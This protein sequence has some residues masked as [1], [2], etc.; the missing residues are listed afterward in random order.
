MHAYKDQQSTPNSNHAPLSDGSIA[1][2]FAHQQ[3]RSLLKQQL[4][5]QVSPTLTKK[6]LQTLN[7]GTATTIL[8]AHKPSRELVT[9]LF[10]SLFT[11][12]NA[13]YQR[14]DIAYAERSQ[15]F[16]SKH[17]LVMAP[18]YCIHTMKDGLRVSAYMRAI[19]KAITALIGGGQEKIFIAYPA[20]GPFAPLLLPLLSHYQQQGL[21]GERLRI[22]LIDIQPGA[23][24]SLHRLITELGLQEYIQQMYCGDAC[25]YNAPMLFDL[26]IVE[27]MQHGF[28]REGHFAIAHHFAQQLSNNGY[29]IPQQV[30]VHAMLNVAQL[31][32]VEQWRNE[33]LGD[34]RLS[35]KLAA[36]TKQRTE[37]GVVMSIT[38]QSLRAIAPS[39]IEQQALIGAATLTIPQLAEHANKQTLSLYTQISLFADERLGLYDSGITHPLPDLSVC[40]NF[41]PNDPQ[42]DDTL[43]NS[44]DT[45]KFYYSL[46]GLPG[47]LVIKE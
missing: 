29:L 7:A 46:S 40:I 44:G 22:T 8:Q 39:Q 35:E 25:S 9:P 30:D 18:D 11:A 23:I 47:F 20:C 43:A 41:V 10:N 31:E 15:Q 2:L 24:N 19:D 13:V 42:A 32:Y 5:T 14:A 16:I 26:V 4:S 33:G 45:L 3:Q 36:I 38:A 21:S 28:S 34:Q 12:Y 27:A 6:E 17:G 1:G 37:L